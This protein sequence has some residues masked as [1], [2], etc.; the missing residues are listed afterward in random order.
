[1]AYIQAFARA[2]EKESQKQLQEL[3]KLGVTGLPDKL[4][5]GFGVA[6]IGANQPFSMAVGLAESIMSHAKTRAKQCQVQNIAPSSVAFF[7]VTT[8]LMEDYSALV[9][10]VLTHYEGDA[11]NRETLS[12]SKCKTYVHT[13]GTYAL[14]VDENV[15]MLPRLSD[16]E[17]LITLLQGVNMARGPVRGLLNLLQLDPVQARASWRRWRQLM[18]DKQRHELSEFDRYLQAL[19]PR[20]QPDA[21]LPYAPCDDGQFPQEFCSPLGDALELLALNHQDFA[22]IQQQEA[23][24]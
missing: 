11:D 21:E 16:L 18:N 7:R 23:V 3:F 8:A 15:G 10:K 19:M 20:Y 5:L 12:P 17:G 24:V 1:L 9:K 22:R 13:L 2:F 4:T 6:F 14:S